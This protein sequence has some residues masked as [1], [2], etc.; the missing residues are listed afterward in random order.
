MGNGSSTNGY[1]FKSIEV[2]TKKSTSK[3]SKGKESRHYMW[4]TEKSI[5]TSFVEANLSNYYLE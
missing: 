3:E 4:Q 1:K 5:D 2:D